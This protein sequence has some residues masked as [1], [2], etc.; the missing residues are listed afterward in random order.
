MNMDIEIGIDDE[1]KTLNSEG[2]KCTLTVKESENSGKDDR[3]FWKTDYSCVKNNKT[4]LSGSFVCTKSLRE[5]APAPTN[6]KGG[7]KKA[8]MMA[9]RQANA[10]K[11]GI[12]PVAGGKGGKHGKKGGGGGKQIEEGYI[13]VTDTLP[14]GPPAPEEN[15]D[16]NCSIQ[17]KISNERIPIE[18]YCCS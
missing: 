18:V 10:A 5:D 8:A 11:L 7:K 17:K 6:Q 15:E 12:T 2:A 4:E 1:S 3:Y 9:K 14:K 16:S 13:D